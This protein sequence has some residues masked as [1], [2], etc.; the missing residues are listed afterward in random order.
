MQRDATKSQVNSKSETWHGRE[1]RKLVG[2]NFAT[3][4]SKPTQPLASTRECA[5][6]GAADEPT[7]M[8]DIVRPLEEAIATRGVACDGKGYALGT[9]DVTVMVA[10]VRAAVVTVGEGGK[11]KRVCVADIEVRG[12]VFEG[13]VT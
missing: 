12:V 6:V 4:Y 13:K 7:P 10:G 9:L 8:N 2:V 11:T 1:A 3:A 5:V